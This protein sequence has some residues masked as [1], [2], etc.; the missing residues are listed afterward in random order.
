MREKD[1]E[2]FNRLVNQQNPEYLWI[3]CSDS[4]VPVRIC[5]GPLLL[6]CYVLRTILPAQSQHVRV[7]PCCYSCQSVIS[8]DRAVCCN[9]R[10]LCSPAGQDHCARQLSTAAETDLDLVGVARVNFQSRCQHGTLQQRLPTACALAPVLTCSSCCVLRCT[11]CHPLLLQANQILGL[12]P[13]EIF[14]QR[15]VG[16]QAMHTDMNLM[17]CLEYAV[18]SLKVGSG[19]KGGGTL[20]FRVLGSSRSRGC[21]YDCSAAGAQSWPWWCAMTLHTDMNLCQAWS[22][23]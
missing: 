22:L 10:R 13:G 12:A 5:T 17:S 11:A 6:C 2:F 7:A 4:R 19:S 15:N 16:N 18:K 3:G 9:V 1:P 8:H 20:G 23:L 14:V 21:H